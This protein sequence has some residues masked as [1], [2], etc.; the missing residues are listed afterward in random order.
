MDENTAETGTDPRTIH[1]TGAG[2]PGDAD[3]LT[4]AASASNASL[5]AGGPLPG[6]LAPSED[7]P[8][9]A[10]DVPSIQQLA[11]ISGRLDT[12]QGDLASMGGQLSRASEAAEL[13]PGLR[14]RLQAAEA[15]IEELQA[16]APP[17]VGLQ[18]KHMT[19]LDHLCKQLGLS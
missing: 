17:A 19:A 10:G 4:G 2:A 1:G 14:D 7:A 9:P 5:A 3:P 6:D 11:A 12:L 13:V 8:E 18:A 16:T 15:T